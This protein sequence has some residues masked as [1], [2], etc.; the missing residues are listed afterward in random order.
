MRT[1]AMRGTAYLLASDDLPLYAAAMRQVHGG[2]DRWFTAFG[3]DAKRAYEVFGAIAA[4]LDGR[5]LSR[6]ELV[7]ELQRR[8]GSW[9]FEVFDPTLAD[10]TAMAAY[11]GVLAYGPPQGAKTTF[12]RADQWC[13]RWSEVDEEDALGEMV[14]RYVAGYGPVTHNDL[15]RWLAI[16]AA[17]ARQLLGSLGDRLTQVDLE[18]TTAWLPAD[19]AEP[20]GGDERDPGRA[21]CLLPQ[22]DCYI[23]GAGPLDRVVAAD[24]EDLIRRRNRGRYEGA[25][26]MSVLLVDG[27]VA[28]VWERQQR[29]RRLDLAVVQVRPRWLGSVPVLTGVPQLTPSLLT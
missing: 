9:V 13:P 2:R 18:G 10:L 5:I 15:A 21:V 28:G 19:D 25:A 6:Q 22:Y 8:A 3:L 12:V 27:I 7:D 17:A 20:A 23:L 26:G 14:H 29:G 4:A 11:A 16:K 24:A 1:Y